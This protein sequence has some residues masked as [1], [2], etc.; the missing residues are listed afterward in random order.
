MQRLQPE[1]SRPRSRPF[2]IEDVH[3]HLPVDGPDASRASADAVEAPAIP[4]HEPTRPQ[5]NALSSCSSY[6]RFGRPPGRHSASPTPRWTTPFP[7]RL[8]RSRVGATHSVRFQSRCRWRQVVTIAPSFP[9]S[10]FEPPFYPFARSTQRLVLVPEHQPVRP[11]HPSARCV[12]Q[13]SSMSSLVGRMPDTLRIAVAVVA[14][15]GRIE[16]GGVC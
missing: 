3:S 9:V 13:A 5:N 15:L 11:S 10:E 2:A 1:N 4:G 8:R 6:E 16:A 14:Q 12:F 7:R